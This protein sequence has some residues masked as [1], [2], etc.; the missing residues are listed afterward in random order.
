MGGAR[1]QRPLEVGTRGKCPAHVRRASLFV[2]GNEDSTVMTTAS[3]TVL[4][5][6]RKIVSNISLLHR[7]K[8]LRSKYT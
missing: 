3:H 6:H 7:F 8:K 4:D 1:E 2:R 5:L